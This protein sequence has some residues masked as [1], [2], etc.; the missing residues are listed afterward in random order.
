MTGHHPHVVGQ[1]QQAMEAVEEPFGAVACVDG[2][3]GPRRGADEQRVAGEQ[4]VAGEEAAVLRP[5]ARRVQRLH[6][7]RADGD[8]VPVLERI[9]RVRGAGV[10]VH[11]HRQ[12]VLERQPAVTG[13]VVGVRVRLEHARDSEATRRGLF[14]ERLDRVR[15]VDEHRLARLFVT[16][17]VRRAAKVVV[18]EL[19]QVHRRRNVPPAPAVLL[20]VRKQCLAPEV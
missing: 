16:D 17:Q 15:R 20:E 18:D 10:G 3:V 4:C 5:V 8:L 11:R 9:V 7:D 13:D 1:L 19:A 12:A 2:E 14:E 6:G